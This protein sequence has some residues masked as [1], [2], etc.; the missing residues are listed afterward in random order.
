MVLSGTLKTSSMSSIINR[1]QGGGPKKAGLVPVMAMT[2][3][4][5]IS[6]KDRGYPKSVNVMKITANPNVKQSRPTEIRPG[7]WYR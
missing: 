2:S 1:N 5:Y 7:N 3:A 4:R 6:F